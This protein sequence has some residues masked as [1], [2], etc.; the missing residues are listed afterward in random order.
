M[1]TSQRK[2]FLVD[3]FVP[4]RNGYLLL[5]LRTNLT[6]QRRNSILKTPTQTKLGKLKMDPTMVILVAFYI[7]LTH[8]CSDHYLLP[9]G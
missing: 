4:V 8:I 5:N 3:R 7:L 1:C 6:N 9:S 2:Q